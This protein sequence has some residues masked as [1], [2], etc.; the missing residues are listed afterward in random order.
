MTRAGEGSR[1]TAFTHLLR[2][3][4]WETTSKGELIR[5]GEGKTYPIGDVPITVKVRADD[6]ENMYEIIEY[7]VRPGFNASF[8]VHQRAEE[9]FLSWKESSNSS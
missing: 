7:A 5:A 1:L 4:P 2:G 9:V 6:T 3:A 8:H